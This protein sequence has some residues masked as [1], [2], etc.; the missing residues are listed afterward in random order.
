MKKLFFVLIIS[1]LLPFSSSAEWH[2]LKKSNAKKAAPQLEILSSDLS[3]ITIK[4]DIS[5]F[6]L[7]NFST[8]KTNYQSLDLL[9]D[10]FTTQPGYPELAHISRVLAVPGDANISVEILETGP[11]QSF[12]NIQLPPAKESWIEGDAEPALVKNTSA[13][14]SNEA[15]PANSAKIDP[16]SIFRDFRICRLSVFPI[17]YIAAK[18]KIEVV[19]SLT[20]RVNFNAGEAI[21]PKTSNPK[22][23]APSFAKLYRSFIFN[24]QDVLDQHYSGQENGREVML[25]I[26][27]DEYANTFQEFTEWKRQSGTDIHITK[28]S[29]IGANAYDPNII[30]D[31]I[32]DAYQNWEYPPTYVLLVGDDGVFPKKIVNYD[33]SFASDNYFSEIEGDDFFPEVMVGRLTNQNDYELQVMLNKFVKYENEPYTADTS[34]FKKGLCCSNNLYL[35]QIETKRFAASTMIQDGGFTSVDT[36]MSDGNEFGYSCTMD[37]NDVMN[38]INEGRSFINYRGEGWSEGWLANCYWFETQFVSSLTN[39][40][41][42]PI[43]TSIGCGVAMFDE[44]N[45]N[46]FGE[47]WLQL[48]TP[49]TPRGAIAFIGPTSNTHTAQNNRIDKGIYMG[50][51]QEG[52]DTPGQALLRGKL[53][54][55]ND[56]G[57]DPWVEYHYRVYCVLG[58]P[59]THIWKDIPLEVNVDHPATVS[60]GFSQPKFVVTHSQSGLPVAN[61]EVCL[62]G[63]DVFSTGFTDSTGTA[64]VGITPT[65][66]AQIMVTVRGGNVIPYQST[67][68]VEQSPEHVGPEGDPIITDLDGN[69]DGKINPNENCSITF[70]L[71]NWGTETANNVQATLTA[72]DTNFVRVISQDPQAFGDLVSGGSKAG[73]PYNFFVKPGCQI[74]QKIEL[75]LHVSSTTSSWDYIYLLEVKGCQLVYHNCFVDDAGSQKQNYRLDPGETARLSVAALNI[76]EDLAPNVHGILRSNDP[77]ITILDS[78]GTYGTIKIDS[79]NYNLEDFF[80]VQVDELCPAEY[81]A[82]FSLKLFTQDANY[83]YETLISFQ[84]AVGV[85]TASEY[86][87]PDEY[88]YYAFDDTDSLYYQHPE[89]AWLEIKNLGT[90]IDVPYTSDYTI[91]VDLPFDFKYYGSQYNK[92]RISTDGWLAMGEGTETNHNNNPLPAYDNV[93]NM[94]APFWGNLH[95]IYFETGTI[96]YYND[97]ANHRFVVEWDSIDNRFSYGK[98]TFQA[99]LLDPAYYPTSTGDG[100]MIFQYKLVGNTGSTTVGIENSTQDV[101]LQY[102]YDNDYAKT[103]AVL[104][105]QRAIKFTTTPPFMYVSNNEIETGGSFLLE[106]NIP[107]PFSESTT[108]CYTLK[109]TT[110]VNLSVFDINGKLIKV[111]ES[112]EQQAGKHTVTWNGMGE[113]G[114]LLSSGIYFYQLKTETFVETKKMFLLK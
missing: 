110:F 53:L 108:I 11:V 31:H 43:L 46:C 55:Y 61:A 12:E 78:I 26:M 58:D 33:Y 63:E 8:D 114:N 101:G 3:G 95:G 18:N 54:M 90:P 6:D 75:N 106:Q 103:S 83:D 72:G 111:I 50:M 52:M 97:E 88:G 17:R 94:I 93:N 56:F 79:S 20:I 73:D 102:C 47:E 113:D 2:P 16:P 14:Q 41:K 100:E 5:G 68:E 1:L 21:N 66:E 9:T 57:T 109:N 96:Y 23:I 107:N 74:G 82:G 84:I 35:S 99:F 87:G 4:V 104:L 34:W 86:S 15:Y 105:G 25:C 92:L 37:L 27:P 59:S 51:F 80:S 70:T 69:M 22:A 65:V 81:Y 48:G 42:L 32:S 40:E 91:T 60:V 39:G 76:G 112:Q 45:V 24:Y 44:E 77:Y 10:I 49:Q 67:M 64:Y 29:D 19:S 36:L 98:E 7:R 30:K 28:F 13:Y 89:Y 85:P 62:L 38:V 71:K